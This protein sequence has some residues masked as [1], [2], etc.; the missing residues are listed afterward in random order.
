LSNPEKEKFSFGSL[1]LTTA[2]F[3]TISVSFT[4]PPLFHLN[5]APNEFAPGF[6][7]LRMIA[8]PEIVAVFQALTEDW[9]DFTR[10]R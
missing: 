10:L 5:I 4:L 1:T 9:I 8:L 6:I 2:L 3:S 7:P